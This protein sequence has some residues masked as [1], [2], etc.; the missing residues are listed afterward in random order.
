L[1]AHRSRLIAPD[2]PGYGK[3]TVP[4]EFAY[5][6]DNLA[7]ATIALLASLQIKAYAMYVFEYGTAG[8]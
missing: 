1:L 6:F 4:A 2:F 5:I 3:T 8:G 7:N